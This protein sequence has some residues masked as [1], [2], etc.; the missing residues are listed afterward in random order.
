MKKIK[1]ADGNFLSIA[2]KGSIKLRKIDLKFVLPVPKLA[3]D[4]LS[5][6][7]LSKDSN[8]HVVF[9]DSHSKFQDQNSEEMI[10]GARM[11]DGVMWATREGC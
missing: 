9:L 2:G 1:I 8:F 11:R 7:K 4:H 5:V 10:H 3:H 6:T